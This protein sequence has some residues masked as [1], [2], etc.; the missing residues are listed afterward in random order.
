MLKDIQRLKAAGDFASLSRLIPYSQVIGLQCAVEDGA[1]VTRLVHRAS[2]IGNYQMA[3]LHGG[4]I[5]AL[6]EHAA[7]FQ[8]FFETDIKAI[9]R[10][11]NIS[12]DYLR[13]SRALDTFASATLVKQGQQIAN[14]RVQAWQ[15]DPTK[16]VAA[17]HTHFLLT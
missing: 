10:I 1:M 2:N 17:A 4:T 6:L 9:P 3:V 5:A 7:I 13:P 16:P 15:T 11:I 12:V 8:L 14:V